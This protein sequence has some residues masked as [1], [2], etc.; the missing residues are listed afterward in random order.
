MRGVCGG[1]SI[2]FCLL[3]GWGI[4]LESGLGCN[5][6][7]LIALIYKSTSGVV[8]V[9]VRGCLIWGDASQVLLALRQSRPEA[10]WF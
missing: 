8:Y 7:Q 4:I 1:G 9:C 3:E 10:G 5:L 2:T 6:V